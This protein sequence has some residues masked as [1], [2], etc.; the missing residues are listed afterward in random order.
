MKINIKRRYLMSRKI[1]KLKPKQSEEDL[2]V[3]RDI[4]SISSIP[5]RE[6]AIQKISKVDEDYDKYIRNLPEKKKQ[7]LINSLNATKLGLH[8]IAPIMCGGP[9]KCPFIAKCPIPDMDTEGELIYGDAADYPIGK[10]CVLEKFYMEQ[11][12]IEYY[13][14]LNIDPNNPVEVSIA[15]E[16]AIIDLYKNRALMIMSV[17]DRSGQGKDF[18]RID[19]LGFNE[20]GEVAEQAK[21]HPA[22]EVIDKLERRREKWLDKLM[23]TRQA[24]AHW[25]LKVGGAQNESKILAEIQKLREAISKI[26]VEELD[27]DD[28]RILLDD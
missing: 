22:V 25:M 18:M 7:R 13:Q 24:K 28:E 9:K 12:L 2:A 1:K 3:S 10:Q 21:L 14:H 8:S 17:G 23:E 26:D 27:V 20:N 4:V 5:T 6:Q 19:I 11:K 16:L 15:N